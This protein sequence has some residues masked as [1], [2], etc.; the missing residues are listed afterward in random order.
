MFLSRDV[1]AQNETEVSSL[2]HEVLSDQIFT[3]VSDA[4]HNPPY[5][6]GGGRDA[7]GRWTGSSSPEKAGDSCRNLD[8]PRGKS[9]LVMPHGLSLT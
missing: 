5:V 7:F 9:S 2:G 8:S 1:A 3:W 6:K 4:E